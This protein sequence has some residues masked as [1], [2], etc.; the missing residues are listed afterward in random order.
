MPSKAIATP[1]HS[2]KPR[3]LASAVRRIIETG[4]IHLG[5]GALAALP[6]LVLAG[7]SGEQIIA[8]N[9]SVVR[10]DAQHTRIDQISQ[11]AIVD[12]HEFSVGNDEYVVFNQPGSTASILNRVVG[13]DPS[14]IL[15]QIS[16]NGRVFLVNS[17]GVYFAPGA[18]VDVA[19][20]TASA[21]DISNEDFLAGRYVFTRPEDAPAG[22]AVRND[23]TIEA[24]ENGFVVLAG[25][26]VNNSGVIA[27]R[28][29]TVVLA[30]GSQMTLQL[31][32]D[33]LVNFA[34]DAEVL[35][36]LAGVENL[37]EIAAD[38]GRVLMTAKV[39]D[40]LIATAVNNSGLIRAQR[41]V[42]ENGEVF[43]RATGGDIAHAG[44]IDVAGAS[45]VDGGR[46]VVTGD[47][48]IAIAAGSRIDADG[49]AGGDGG[50]V[51]II[52]D[53]TLAF[54]R[55]AT[56][57]ALAGDR[58]G[59]GGLLELSGHEDLQ[60]GGTAEL[61]F[62]GELLLDPNELYFISGSAAPAISYGSVTEVGDAFVEGQLNQGTNVTLYATNRIGVRG[63][64]FTLDANGG[65]DLAL[66]IGTL[67]Y[68]N[69]A[70][71]LGGNACS[72][73]GV[74][75]D[76][77]T[78]SFVP[79]R[80]GDIDL[81]GMN[82]SI[83]GD[84]KFQA[85]TN[86]GDVKT[87]GLDADGAIDIQAGVS[88]SSEAHARIETG[89]IAAGGNVLLTAGNANL[90]PTIVQTGNVSA[91]LDVNV[92]A[93]GPG[94]Q[95]TLGV[96]QAADDL[97]V[98]ALAGGVT[99]NKLTAGGLGDGSGEIKVRALTTSGSIAVA[100][101]VIATGTHKAW[102]EFEAK[103]IHVG[104]Q[105][106]SSAGDND[107]ILKLRGNTGIGVVDVDGAILVDAGRSAEAW[108]DGK[109]VDLAGGITVD[110]TV[111]DAS[112]YAPN[113]QTTLTIS[114]G[115]TVRS[116]QR[117][118]F[119][120]IGGDDVTINGNI[121]ADA[122]EEVW[123]SLWSD[124]NTGLRTGSLTINGNVTA[125]GS[126]GG[127]YLYGSSGD[128]NVTG[129]LLAE[130][131]RLT[132]VD[133]WSVANVNV[134]G[135]VTANGGEASIDV[136]AEGNV[137][138]AGAVRA[139]GS[140]A[141]VHINGTNVTLGAGVV[142]QASIYD[143]DVSISGSLGTVNITG[144]V[145]ARS[146]GSDASVEISGT[147]ISVT[148]NILAHGAD[149]GD[150]DIETYWESEGGNITVTGTV[151]A[152]GDSDSASVYFSGRNVT[153]GGD[154]LVHG[155]SET[156]VDL[157]AAENLTVRNVTVMGASYASLSIEADNITV[158]GT[159]KSSASDGWAGME[160]YAGSVAITGDVIARSLTSSASIDIS[161]GAVTIGGNLLAH[162]TDSGRIRLGLY[163]SSES[164]SYSSS[165]YTEQA[166][167]ST[168]GD[169]RVTGNV[170]ARADAGWARIDI[171]GNDVT[172]G[173]AMLADAGS[174]ASIEVDAIGNVT[175]QA[176]SALGSSASI[177]L[178]GRN[179][180]IN[181]AMLASG[182]E[183][184]GEI[185][186]EA[187]GTVTF[188]GP[189]RADV[190]YGIGGTSVR[191]SGSG[192]VEADYVVLGLTGTTGGT[193]DAKTKTAM[194]AFGGDGLID[195]RIDNS[196]FTGIAA[197]SFGSDEVSDRNFGKMDLLSG[198][199]LTVSTFT[200]RSLLVEVPGMFVASGAVTIAGGGS[201]PVQPTDQ[202]LFDT[203]TGAGLSP[204]NHGPDLLIKATTGIDFDSTLA[205]NGSTPYLKLFSDGPTVM[206]DHVAGATGA[207]FTVVYSPINPL[208]P[209]IFESQPFSVPV[210]S[211]GYNAVNHFA[212]IPGTTIMFG[213]GTAEGPIHQGP[214]TIGANGI[215]DIGGDNLLMFTSGEVAGLGN[216]IS[217]GYVVQVGRS[218]VSP[219]QIPV[220][221]EF[222]DETEAA[223]GDDEDDEEEAI[224]DLS[225]DESE[226][227][228]DIVE[229][230]NVGQLECSA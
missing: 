73:V 162:G 123:L 214:F 50:N 165:Q 72:P 196:A 190:V 127:L 54:R 18:R 139:A 212:S 32:D 56:I 104:G 118:T 34:V 184:S 229:E 36:G 71:S 217:T 221:S 175:L 173:G 125:I 5:W 166:V 209:V 143:A 133:V 136:N 203:M 181:G 113:Y 7:P 69:S 27:G 21:L 2:F 156:S 124:N 158:N 193:V 79:G 150:V 107:A 141:D 225:G 155:D 198:G 33:G 161:A 30:S 102:I 26:Y 116:Q 31:G 68:A 87:S 66:R 169:I 10:P 126:S 114:G 119:V 95:V 8:G 180:T 219:L 58:A 142:A 192:I 149:D 89:D 93:R 206:P 224:E 172:V 81:T 160:I 6:G 210:G 204:P 16:A 157:Y 208:L 130:G 108:I 101:D 179:V 132:S 1:N 188:G 182:S 122:D 211:V 168:P 47:H 4:T 84:L 138:L 103:N 145:T 222:T 12:W 187:A 140:S 57:S 154:L 82:I 174:E 135:A 213:E 75:S 215:I 146:L 201:M 17:R 25:D 195:L 170:T 97:Y 164:T 40:G 78:W 49:G 134:G 23:G 70:G 191:T 159:L 63:T 117:S 94:A 88:A 24:G 144:D 189:T 77:S 41:I 110:A 28:L 183:S 13:S 200:T 199:S 230:S 98:N 207:E 227:Q 14:A 65:G 61:G 148:G 35:S 99:V 194:G 9:A 53:G 15:G 202:F 205:F 51:R 105:I 76:G 52:A 80:W 86:G 46:V 120:E 167:S 109:T 92:L 121:L 37:G 186:V 60:L 151:T 218:A 137:T 29:G 226:V 85:G 22:V 20:I 62:G 74:C 90:T 185:G 44:T 115:V 42:E 112:F 83:G 216:V 38:G 55:E 45:G 59:R 220:V 11:A 96:V 128:V 111:G 39:A 43:L 64:G 171:F 223:A 19:A 178:W 152:T 3:P 67:V 147:T 91:G 131:T 100:Q 48:D 163:V 106:K 153:I 129:A 177:E 228:Q 176:V 197:F